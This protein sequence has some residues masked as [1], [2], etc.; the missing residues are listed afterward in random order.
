MK[1]AVEYCSKADLNLSEK[2]NL[3]DLF[4]KFWEKKCDIY[5]NETNIMDSSK[6]EVKI[7]KESYLGKHMKT[8]LISLFSLSKR[9]K[10]GS[11]CN[12]YL[13]LGAGK[14]VS[15]KW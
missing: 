13:R 7:K 12:K 10:R 15:A 4:N 11:W 2:F 1:E 3:L 6:P 9:N 14:Q 8:S 5:F